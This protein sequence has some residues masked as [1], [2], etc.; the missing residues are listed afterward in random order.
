MKKDIIYISWVIF[1]IGI[2]IITLDLIRIGN[3]MEKNGEW[4]MQ[5]AYMQGISAKALQGPPWELKAGGEYWIKYYKSDEDMTVV[6]IFPGR[7]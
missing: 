5:K 3:I 4:E 6:K 1:L 2:L 7:K